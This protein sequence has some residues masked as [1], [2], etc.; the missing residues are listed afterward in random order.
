[1]TH[2]Y[3]T[4]I[5]YAAALVSL[6]ACSPADPPQTTPPAL[7]VG[8]ATSEAAGLAAL[9]ATW[10]AENSAP[11]NAAAPATLRPSAAP[12]ATATRL[13]SPDDWQSAPVVPQSISGRAA[14]IY[15]HG[16]EL[17]SNPQAFS[18]VGDCG[19]TP[20]WF[21]GSF[22]LDAQYYSLGEYEYLAAMFTHYAG[23]FERYSLAVSPGFNTASVFAPLWADPELCSSDEGPL[24]CELRINRPSV[25][26]IMLG[27]ND[28]YHPAEFEEPM[29]KII[30]YTIAQGALPILSSKADNLEG[31][32]SINRTLYKLS[33]EYEL[34]FWNFW[35]AV[36]YLPNQGMQED[37]A[38][39]T[40]APNYFDRPD[41]LNT[42]WAMRNLTALQALYAVWQALPQP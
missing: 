28:Q 11:T 41:A 23:S 20:S 13:A 38:H 12:N 36:Q 14:E 26:L 21:L 16:L 9:I 19:G 27:T 15:L 37:G 18:K 2:K 4:I 3:W 8:T 34:P 42:G 1:M 22:D 6:A 32:H 33:L 5:Y 30:E 31:D 10:E 40:W 25:V 7:Q 35:L 24:A 39:L 17:G 29:R